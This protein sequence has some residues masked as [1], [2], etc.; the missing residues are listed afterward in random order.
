MKAHLID[1]PTFFFGFVGPEATVFTHSLSTVPVVLPPGPGPPRPP[2]GPCL[3][4]LKAPLPLK[5][6]LP[7]YW[8]YWAI[9]HMDVLS[10][11]SVDS[12]HRAWTCLHV[13]S[14][15][16]QILMHSFRVRLEPFKMHCWYALVLLRPGMMEFL[17][18]LSLQSP[19]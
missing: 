6:C 18:S 3:L 14:S 17:I 19:M 11:Q 2:L 5:L 13:A 4:P 1:G 8:V 10:V 12:G 15:V 9:L 7:C 16:W